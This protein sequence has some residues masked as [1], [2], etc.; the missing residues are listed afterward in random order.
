MECDAKPGVDANGVASNLEWHAH[1][2][3][4]AAPAEVEELC[5]LKGKHG[6]R[7]MICS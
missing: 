2:A 3:W 7:F 6:G 4:M 1:T 5:A